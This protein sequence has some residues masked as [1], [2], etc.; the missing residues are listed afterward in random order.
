MR[1]PERYRTQ[2]VRYIPLGSPWST[3]NCVYGGVRQVELV[4]VG[5]VQEGGYT[6]WGSTGWVPG[7]WYTGY[8]PSLVSDWYC[9]GPTQALHAYL[10]P[11]RHSRGLSGPFRTPGLLALRYAPGSQI[12]RDSGYYILKLVNIPECHHKCVMRPAIL[13]VSKKAQESTTLNFQDFQYA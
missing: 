11:P 9:Q 3:S 10:R 12:G 1:L 13:P 4:V 2:C 7:G 5:W 8:V 6:G